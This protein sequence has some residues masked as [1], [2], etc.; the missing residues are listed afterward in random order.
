MARDIF[1]FLALVALMAG[2]LALVVIFDLPL[3]H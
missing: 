2:V 1:G 3:P